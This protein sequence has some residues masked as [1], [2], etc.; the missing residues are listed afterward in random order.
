MVGAVHR[1]PWEDVTK[2]AEFEGT[3]FYL[4]NRKDNVFDQSLSKLCFVF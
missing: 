1:I 3:N 4:Y 2:L